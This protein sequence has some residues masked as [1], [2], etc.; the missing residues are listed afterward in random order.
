MAALFCRPVHRPALDRARRRV[1]QRHRTAATCLPSSCLCGDRARPCWAIAGPALIPRTR[2]PRR[3]YFEIAHRCAIG[4]QVFP[5]L[6]SPGARCCRARADRHGLLVSPAFRRTDPGFREGGYHAAEPAHRISMSAACR[7]CPEN[8]RS[9]LFGS[10]GIPAGLLI[11]L[12]LPACFRHRPDLTR[13]GNGP[14]L[15]APERRAPRCG[16]VDGFAFRQGLSP[17]PSAASARRIRRTPTVALTPCR[18]HPSRTARELLCRR[19]ADFVLRRRW[20]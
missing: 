10:R 8:R 17:A 1:T 2:R 20:G 7:P 16:A 15:V 14:L 13:L 4:L 6:H 5:G 12:R 11:P 18:A 3:L 9:S 19:S